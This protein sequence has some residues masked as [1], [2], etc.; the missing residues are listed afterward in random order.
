MKKF[1][2]TII[3]VLG[4][5]MPAS[6]WAQT[7]NTGTTGSDEAGNKEAYVVLSEDNTVVTFYYDDQKATRGG[8][9]INTKD[10]PYNSKS[11]Y[12]SATSAVFDNSF[13]DYFPTSTA[14]WFE[15]CSSLVTISGIQN[16]KTD[17]V[18]KMSLMFRD[19]SGLTSLDVSGFKTDNVTDMQ[20]MF[21]GCS[22]LT[23][24]DVSGF[25]TDKVTTMSNMFSGCSVLT[26]LDVSG[27]KT[28]NVTSMQGMFEGCSGLTTLDVSGFKTDKVTIMF[29]MFF[30]CSGLTSLDVSGFKTDNVTDM[31]GM[32]YRCS[33]LTTLD[34]SGFKT[35][36]VT[37]ME[38]MFYR[39]SGLTSLDV[40]G[41]KTDNVTNMSWMFD[42]CSGLTSLD[43]SDFKTDNVTDMS[44]MFSGCSELS[45]IYV[46]DAWN[47]TNVKAS[48]YM[49]GGSTK[50][51]GGAGTKYDRNHTDHTYAHI[52]GGADNPGYFTRSGDAPYTQKD[53][54]AT[55]YFEFSSDSLK[56]N[57]DTEGAS[58]QY[59]LT[60]ANAVSEE[61]PSYKQ[62]G[63]PILINYDATIEAFATKENFE[64]SDTIRFV[65]PYTDWQNLLKTAMNA[66]DVAKAAEGNANVPADSV[67]KL[68]WMADEAIMRYDHERPYMDSESINQI[69]KELQ[70]L[71]NQIEEMM[72]NSEQKEQ[73]ATPTFSIKGDSVYVSCATEGASIWYA[74]AEMDKEFAEGFAVYNGPIYITMD[75]KM[76]AKATKD[77]MEES[78]ADTLYY[79]YTDWQNLLKITYSG[80]EV[81][82]MARNNNAVPTNLITN[83]EDSCKLGQYYYEE[84]RAIIP[85]EQVV[86]L[87]YEIEDMINKIQKL[88]EQ[89]ANRASFDGTT[90][91]VEG[92]TTMASA[93]EQVGGRAEV[94]KTI[95]AIVWNST[96]TLSASDL[97]GIDNP[98][99]LIFVPAD[100][101]APQ[102]VNN[103]VVN[104]K[105]KNIVLVDGAT[106]NN[107]FYSP[108][109]FTAESISYTREFKQTTE[110]DVSRGW[111]GIALPFT[112]QTFTHET[113]GAIA[114]F[115]NT[116]SNYHFWLHEM[117]DKGLILATTI[118]A[119][120]PYIISM[121]NNSVYPAE[122]N[123]AGK[124]TFSAQNATIPAST[125][126]E[127]W[128]ADGSL[129][130]IATFRQVEAS[131][132]VYALN[133]GAEV[134]GRVEGSV[135][136]SNYRAIRP[137]EVYTFHEVNGAESA[138]SRFITISSL[139]GGDGATAIDHVIKTQDSEYVKVYNL[140]GTL[141]K[142][143]YRDEIIRTLP[144][145]IYIINNRKL[146]I[147]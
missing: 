109:E 99:M 133:V 67:D 13:A 113:H 44:G 19:C 114:P 128:T 70:D 22:G 143:G 102:G 78:K 93:L 125:Q 106:G 94:A 3:A 32:F 34:V 52:D 72:K 71:I 140:N 73:V 7:G 101:L 53:K 104:G 11:P 75:W 39:C 98:N 48:N 97:Q 137:F 121:P 108:Q 4:I 69:T 16:L 31:W 129:A 80:Q 35:D 90:L 141:L 54:V 43:V 84:Q 83:L 41:F 96:A 20:Q 117:T 17:K 60:A 79:Y 132:R 30:G 118:E 105:A 91:T 107:N 55:P 127:V 47:T 103:V 8:I 82:N 100:S 29:G 131:N 74:S 51:V 61:A 85:R 14:H 57:C 46:A 33:G 123:H 63:E 25:K 27:F 62:Y 76:I 6:L 119:G 138:G 40:S 56:I 147:R 142:Q 130:M 59:M 112:V 15:D 87:T 135:F 37:N 145:G 12:G 65:Y 23:S 58:V 124:V 66:Q 50:L 68:K 136:V 126:G 45:T 28:D 116:K 81:A 92:E 134:E 77:G 88:I 24:L 89:A 1:I 36:N 86:K 139:F 10:I 38:S 49:F 42:D 120:K 5:L 21:Y 18:T 146:I 95:A 115:R 111:E 2:Y 64:N 26:S 9:D 122:Y 110:I 144:K